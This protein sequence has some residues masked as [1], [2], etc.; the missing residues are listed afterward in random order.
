MSLAPQSTVIGA[1][2]S[3]STVHSQRSSCLWL[4]SPQSEVLVSLAP[5]REP[6]I[7]DSTVHNQRSSYVPLAPVRGPRT[8]AEAE[9]S[10]SLPCIRNNYPYLRHSRSTQSRNTRNTGYVIIEW[11][12]MLV[13]PARQSSA[14]A[15]AIRDR[16]HTRPQT[17]PSPDTGRSIR[18]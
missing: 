18:D 4:H 13:I 11:L 17:R 12:E 6:R 9:M 3:G 5:V 16:S 15:G 7:S 8:G 10:P 2:V 1:R 14:G